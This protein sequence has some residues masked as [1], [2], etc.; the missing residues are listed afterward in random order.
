M[1]RKTVNIIFIIPCFNASK[2]LDS[3]Y[4]SLIAQSNKLWR[5]IF[6]DDISTDDTWEKLEEISQ[7]DKDNRIEIHKNKEKCFALKNIIKFAR[8]Y[9]D[10]DVIIAVIDGDDELCNVNVVNILKEQYFLGYEVVWTA[11]KWDINGINISRD[12]PEKVNP[13]QW[14]WCS[15]HLRTF[16]SSLL[17][18][19]PDINFKDSKGEWFQRGYDQALMLPLMYLTEKRKYVGEVCYLYKINSVSV[20]DRDW[21]EHKQISTINFVRA[22]GFIANEL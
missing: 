4:S 22:R 11:H 16:K 14:Q 18:K 21:A 2:N 19:V 3:L 13:Y 15:S 9:Q 17:R 20:N 1:A 6:I 7:K 12:I 5:A 10:K 8:K